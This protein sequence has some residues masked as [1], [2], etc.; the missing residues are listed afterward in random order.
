MM[1]LASSYS[2]LLICSDRHATARLLLHGP[3]V[4]AK[5]EIS[6]IYTSLFNIFESHVQDTKLLISSSYFIILVSYVQ[7]TD[8]LIPFSSLIILVS[9]RYA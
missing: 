5:H 7:N 6:L 8:F 4:R 1:L 2:F 9:I 3:D